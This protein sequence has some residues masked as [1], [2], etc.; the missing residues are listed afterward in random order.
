MSRNKRKTVLAARLERKDE[1]I[2]RMF[3]KRKKKELPLLTASVP[4]PAPLPDRHPK[5]LFS[6]FV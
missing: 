1:E 3:A 4:F 5:P 6:L 2:V